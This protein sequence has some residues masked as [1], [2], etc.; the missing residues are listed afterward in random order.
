MNNK[1]FDLLHE[2]IKGTQEVKIHAQV[3]YLVFTFFNIDL[4]IV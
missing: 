1:N 2:Y 3:P 4:Y